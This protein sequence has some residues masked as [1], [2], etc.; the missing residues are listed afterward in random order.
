[1]NANRGEP[2]ILALDIGTSSVR[3]MLFTPGGKELPPG[4]AQLTWRLDMP[5][6]G[7]AQIDPQRL[8]RQVARCIDRTLEGAGLAASRIAAV[9]CC[10]FWHSLVGVDEQCR[11]LTP[12]ITWADTRPGQSLDWLSKRIDRG[13]THRR[14]GCPLHASYLPAKLVW[15]RQTQPE[16]FRAV[17]YWMSPVDFL[18]ARL[19]GTRATSY[20]MASATGL[21]DQRA[22][23]WD[24][25]L[26][27]LVKIDPEQLGQI[28]PLEE[29]CRGLQ[30]PWAKRWP[31]LADVPWVRGV[32]DGAASNVGS[33][34]LQ[35]GVAALM[36]GTSAA[37]RV[38]PRQRP[39]NLPAG[40]WC[41]RVERDWPLVG[42]AMS[43]GGVV[44]D[45][46]KRVL[47][48]PVDFESRIAGLAP[49]SHG[50]AVLPLL[51]GERT[52]GWRSDVC[53]VIAGLGIATG[54]LEMARAI[55]ESVGMRCAGMV[56]LLDRALGQPVRVVGTGAG[57]RHS[58][59]WPQIIADALGRPI[60][61]STVAEGSSR[62]AALL[63][64][65]AVG[66]GRST[67]ELRQAEPPTERTIEPDLAK[68][69]IYRELAGK[70]RKLYERH[71]GKPSGV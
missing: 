68:T 51:L 32:G 9:G 20:S 8:V 4:Q 16:V 46:M 13:Q 21:Y 43:N 66:L 29:V 44:F 54:P 64:A 3:S 62:G 52:P 7:A 71:F 30:L 57:L 14:T 6:P 28:V 39:R 27:R 38:G 48:L 19:F 42:G 31:G 23:A 49:G 70:S 22:N 63:A 69:P 1:M 37:V 41:Y 24:Q 40:L 58:R 2:L 59:L 50:L 25:P 60:E 26:C 61:I 47:R 34:C 15:L 65:Q 11:P 12:I 17:R 56:E 67:D 53:G 10:G 36:V 55:M 45:W 18:Y 5:E 33:E 35:P